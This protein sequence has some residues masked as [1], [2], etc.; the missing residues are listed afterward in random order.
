MDSPLLPVNKLRGECKQG[1]FDM[2]V[3]FS[4]KVLALVFRQE[5]TSKDVT[6]R[7]HCEGMDRELRCNEMEKEVLRG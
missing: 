4:G 2:A 6:H 1:E 3:Q 7:P 5:Q